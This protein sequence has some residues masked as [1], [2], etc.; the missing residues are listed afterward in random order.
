MSAIPGG[1][2]K[3]TS[4]SPAFAVQR[5]KTRIGFVA[6]GAVL[7]VETAQPG[8][9]RAV[10]RRRASLLAGSGAERRHGCP[11]A[12]RT[13]PFARRFGATSPAWH[14]RLLA[15]G[16]SMPTAQEIRGVSYAVF[17]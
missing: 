1:Q 11:R 5:R 15:S 16:S 13:A 6:P 10:P 17:V 9:A 7:C 12:V 2:K 8:I 4:L 3:A 14:N